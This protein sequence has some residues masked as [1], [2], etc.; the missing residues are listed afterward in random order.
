MYVGFESKF[1]TRRQKTLQV[2]LTGTHKLKHFRPMHFVAFKNEFHSIKIR[3]FH[4]NDQE[5]KF[6][7]KKK[8][9]GKRKKLWIVY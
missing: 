1:L 8:K 5:L 6:S 9:K 2:E 3:G 7:L 4:K